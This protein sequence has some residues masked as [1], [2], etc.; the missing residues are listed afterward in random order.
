MDYEDRLGLTLIAVSSTILSAVGLSWW[1]A[2]RA[3]LG[4]AIVW[5]F[6]VW[7]IPLGS[8]AVVKL[9][10]WIVPEPEP[11]GNEG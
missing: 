4:E 8:V 6:A 11:G 7:G 5:L 9:I 10:N 3:S 1:A 2:G